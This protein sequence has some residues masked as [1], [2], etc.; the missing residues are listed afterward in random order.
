MAHRGTCLHG[1]IPHALPLTST[2][3]RCSSMRGLFTHPRKTAFP[4]PLTAPALRAA[5]VHNIVCTRH[6]P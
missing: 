4:L 3:R 1:S 2:P 5:P 6:I